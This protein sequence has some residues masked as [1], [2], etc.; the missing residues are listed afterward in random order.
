MQSI[1]AI[2]TY[3]QQ[4]PSEAAPLSASIDALVHVADAHP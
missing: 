4:E 3:L 1:D 2:N